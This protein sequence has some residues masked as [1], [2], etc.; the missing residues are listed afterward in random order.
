MTT[1][2]EDTDGCAKQYCF[3]NAIYLMP[4]TSVQYDIVIDRTIA[5]I[6][7]GNDVVDGL[8]AVAKAYLKIHV[9]SLSS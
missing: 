5:A 6:G 2:W 9:S 8:N 1:V 7:H 4:L 3:T